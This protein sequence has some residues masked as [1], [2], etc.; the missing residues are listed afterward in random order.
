LRQTA[1]VGVTGSVG[2]TTTKE[3]TA[4][5]LATRL[6]VT[7]NP[8]NSNRLSAI[9]RTILR[10]RR[11]HESC[12]L[13]VAAWYPGSVAAVARLMQPTI[14]VVTRIGLDHYRAFRS[15]EAVALEKRALVDALPPAGCAILNADDPYAIAM[16]E[17]FEGRV[18]SFGEAAS[19]TVRASGLSSSWPDP[20]AFR[21]HHGQREWPVQTRLH[22]KHLATSVLAAVS[23]GIA[24][25]VPVESALEAVAA[26]EP[27][28][29]RMSI[30]E[31]DGATFVRDDRKAPL[32]AFPPVLEFVSEARAA[33]T[34]L[35]VGTISDYP[36]ASARRYRGLAE[37]ALAS[38]DKVVFVGRN[39]RMAL[40]ARGDFA[41]RL[42]AF[43][44]LAEA[45]EYLE[46][47]VQAGDLVLLK[48]SRRA[49]NLARLVPGGS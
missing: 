27:L 16:A 2:K 6:A 22:G 41:G 26:F 3:L 44:T 10:T 23:V 35:V 17:G 1:F 18:I 47:E 39:S 15:L 9:G 7:S 32:W 24:L 4:A 49:D 36:G 29:G 37:Q 30:V 25:G 8:G 40:R 11:R 34:L 33:R 46:A 28:P 13:E 31:H 38:A 5:V 14:A 45:R 43:E 48:G 42:Y 20:L 21:L 19:A 12:V